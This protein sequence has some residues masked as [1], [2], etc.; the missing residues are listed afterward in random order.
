MKAGMVSK[1]ESLDMMNMTWDMNAR[2]MGAKGDVMTRKGHSLRRENGS[3]YR[4]SDSADRRACPGPT[5][6]T[7]HR[8]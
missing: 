4:A 1:K 5:G 7:S 2:K 3:P 6:G 8:A